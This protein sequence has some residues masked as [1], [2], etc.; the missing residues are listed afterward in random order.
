MHIKP[1][2]WYLEGYKHS[3]NG[4]GGHHDQRLMPA[5]APS[6]TLSLQQAAK[7]PSV[8]TTDQVEAK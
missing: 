3:R 1:L 4:E 8:A 5:S 2:T 7:P 6:G